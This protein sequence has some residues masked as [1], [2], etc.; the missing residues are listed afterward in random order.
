MT[1]LRGLVDGVVEKSTP[2]QARVFPKYDTVQGSQALLCGVGRLQ[3]KIT[4]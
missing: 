4:A 3:F 2:P 1:D